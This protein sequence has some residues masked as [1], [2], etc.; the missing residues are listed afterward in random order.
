MAKWKEMPVPGTVAQPDMVN[1]P[2]HYNHSSIEAI[3]Y[4]QDNLGSGYSHY[5]DGNV[6]KYMHRW[7]YKGGVEDLKKANWYLEKLIQ[8]VEKDVL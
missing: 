2:P 7:R 5:L 4:I 6:K 3:D 1:S 8:T